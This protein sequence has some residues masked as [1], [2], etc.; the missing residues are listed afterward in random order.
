MN[1]TVIQKRRLLEL[2][3]QYLQSTV[4][5]TPEKVPLK[6]GYRATYN[7]V[8]CRCGENEIWQNV[9]RFQS[10][11]TFTD[12]KNRSVVFFGTATN[13]A[14]LSKGAKEYP[15]V[16]DQDSGKV[17][18]TMCRSQRYWWYYFLRLTVEDDL[19]AE[20]EEI[21]MPEQVLKFDA[22][23]KNYP[24]RIQTLDSYVPESERVS[25]EELIRIADTYWQGCEKKISPEEVLIHPDCGRL[26]LGEQCLNAKRNFHTARSS[27]RKSTFHW[28]IKNK[29]WYIADE[30]RGLA[31]CIVEFTQFSE[32]TPP[33]F[34]AAEAF[35][36]ENGLIKDIMAFLHYDTNDS[37]WRSDQIEKNHVK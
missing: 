13:E 24:S 6:N 33:G 18:D 12:I 7:G 17:I 28:L 32:N 5:N 14:Q 19:I 16:K 26:E 9:L 35:K 34:L 37:G 22:E 8:E 29:R 31:V 4:D 15:K 27:M 1:D 10:R 2:L 23:A 20:V 21:T 30:E 11:Q 25:R 3:N 36:I